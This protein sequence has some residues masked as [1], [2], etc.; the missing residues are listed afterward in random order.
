MALFQMLGEAPGSCLVKRK[1]AHE[2]GNSGYVRLG[3]SQVIG[4]KLKD[5][6]EKR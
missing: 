3:T 4:K 6:R 2:E 5:T 1:A